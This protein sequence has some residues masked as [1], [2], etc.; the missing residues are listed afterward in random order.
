M[1]P[2]S[3]VLGYSPLAIAAV[4]PVLLIWDASIRRTSAVPWPAGLQSMLAIGML[5][6]SA[7]A[8]VSTVVFLSSYSIVDTTLHD[9]SLLIFAALVALLG[10]ACLAT[11]TAGLVWPA[12]PVH[13]RGF[14]SAVLVI[15][16][17]VV[18]LAAWYTAKDLP[19]AI[20]SVLVS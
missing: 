15:D 16:A 1:D 14:T 2:I 13:R 19:S 8:V 4:L 3:I 6:C 17:F 10:T 12:R 5:L 9:R 20:E 18:G 7:G 11:L